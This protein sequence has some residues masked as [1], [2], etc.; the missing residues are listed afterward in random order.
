MRKN[1][2]FN[3]T[4]HWKDNRHYNERQHHHI[5]LVIDSFV[6]TRNHYDPFR[7]KTIH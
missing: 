3:S 1:N 6:D 5:H 2:Q 4:G 7:N